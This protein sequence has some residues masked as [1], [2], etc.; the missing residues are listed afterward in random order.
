MLANSVWVPEDPKLS[1]RARGFFLPALYSPLG[2]YSWREAAE[3]F[4]KSKGR[5]ETL[6][7]FINTV[8]GE[9]F[10]ESGEAPEWKTLYNRRER[11][12]IGIVPKGAVVLTAGFDIQKDRIEGE[13]VGWGAGLESWSVDYRVFPG[14][15]ASTDD[16]WKLLRA[17]LSTTYKHASGVHLRVRMTAIDTGYA[18]QRAYAFVRSFSANKVIAVKGT[19]SMSVLVAQ[20]KAVDVQEGKRRLSRGLHVYMVGTDQ[21]KQELYGLLRIVQP[22]H[23]ER[24]GWP[25]GY[26]HFPDY[27]DEYFQ[28]LC[29]EQLVPR[30]V[31]GYRRYQWEKIR[32]RNEARDCR[33]SARAAAEVIGRARWRDEHWAHA[34]ATLAGEV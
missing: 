21:A 8:L 14:D 4:E 15:P 30:M 2:W 18:T 1:H 9:T 17:W 5:S 12:T 11:Y 28:Q 16:P 10:T 23:P 26:C 34:K 6:R 33:N 27:P 24:D 7:V 32:E 25:A 3:L 19:D 31:R 13:V 22:E 20:P 29:A